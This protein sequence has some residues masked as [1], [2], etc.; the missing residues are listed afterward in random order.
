[1]RGLRRGAWA[2]RSAAEGMLVRRE[3][4]GG[5]RAGSQVIR[6]LWVRRGN[7]EGGEARVTCSLRLSGIRRLGLIIFDYFVDEFRASGR[8]ILASQWDFGG[9]LR[10]VWRG[11]SIVT[12]IDL[13][14]ILSLKAALARQCVG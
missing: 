7:G 12:A 4:L 13:E 10:E 3:R 8:A 9:C 1:M 2:F 14:A 5:L 11:E 6:A